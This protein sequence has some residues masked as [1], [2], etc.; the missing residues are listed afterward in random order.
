MN[1]TL[2]DILRLVADPIVAVA[3][4]ANAISVSITEAI[5]KSITDGIASLN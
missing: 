3:N 2:D 5:A 4:E 1:E